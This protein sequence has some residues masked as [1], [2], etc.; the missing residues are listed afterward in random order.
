MSTATPSNAQT[1]TRKAFEDK[2]KAQV[3][4]AKAKLEQYEA[5]AKEKRVPLSS[6]RSL[7]LCAR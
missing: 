7:R 1:S 5:S 3:E 6:W 2:I 4:D